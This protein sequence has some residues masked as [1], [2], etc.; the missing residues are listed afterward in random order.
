MNRRGVECLILGVGLAVLGMECPANAQ[1]YSLHGTVYGS[2]QDCENALK[3]HGVEGSVAGGVAGALLGTAV[4]GH[5]HGVGAGL[6]GVAGAT[7]GGRV[8]DNGTCQPVG[9]RVHHAAV[10]QESYRLGDCAL[11]ADKLISPGGSLVTSKA[12]KMCLTGGGWAVSP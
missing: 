1:E 4:G 9:R 5:S 2:L 8:A 3:R 11:G 7:M 10:V 6:G 12:V